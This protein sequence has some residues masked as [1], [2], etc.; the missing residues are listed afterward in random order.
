MSNFDSF[1][2]VARCSETQLYVREKY[3]SENGVKCEIKVE[4]CLIQRNI[5]SQ[6]NEKYR[7]K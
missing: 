6:I 5:T 3:L 4:I 1:E 7:I 2:T